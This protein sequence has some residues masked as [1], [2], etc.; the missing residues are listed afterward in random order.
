MARVYGDST[1][2]PYDIDFIDLVRQSLDCG[3]QLLSAQHSINVAGE[4]L[5][6][7]EAGQSETR[8]QIGNMLDAVGVAMAHFEV[9]PDA[10]VSAVARAIAERTQQVVADAQ[11]GL[12]EELTMLGAQTRGIVDRAR[13]SAHR[14][15][16]TLLRAHDLPGSVL[17]LELNAGEL[18]YQGKVSLRTS[19]GVGA[20][21]SISIPS[22]HAWSKPRRV[23]E[24]TQGAEIRV[25]RESGWISKRT[26]LMPTKLDKL[27]VSDVKLGNVQSSVRLRKAPDSGSG[28][29]LSVDL[30]REP[31][32]TLALVREDGSLG[33]EPP[34]T[35][36]EEDGLAA[37]ALW[38]S[39]ADSLQD[40]FGRRQAM[41]SAELDERPL[42]E[43]ESPRVIAERIVADLAPLTLEIARRSGA[44][45]ELVLRRDLGEGR[46][47]ETY[48][49]KRELLEKTFVLPPELR[50]V[51]DPLGL[52]ESSRLA[53]GAGS[54]PAP[55]LPPP[56][57]SAAPRELSAHPVAQS[58]VHVAASDLS[59]EQA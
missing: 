39:L 59:S 52:G 6:S 36:S 11:R 45:G 18:G 24:L 48:A 28:Y 29:Q 58:S 2:F 1:P 41:L 27:F 16:E 25:P 51:F 12:D 23:S 44:P 13:E 8:T 10:R 20:V 40:L 38:R 50:S 21:F 17:G 26:E 33:S 47:E 55:A 9:A 15:L 31:R 35:L 5:R 19:F 4:R 42:R 34:L 30:T 3:I 53:L 49:T 43:L 32:M 54:L 56:P 46:R 37:I 22:E 57:P 14:A 7:V